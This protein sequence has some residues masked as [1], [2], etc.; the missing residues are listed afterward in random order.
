MT[1]LKLAPDSERLRRIARAYAAGEMDEEEYRRIRAEVIDGFM[2]VDHT[3]DDTEQRWS[4][5]AT[6]PPPAKPASASLWTGQL[7]SRGLRWL[8]GAAVVLVSSIVLL[9]LL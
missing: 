9:L 3:A 1:L 5:P 8:L 7:T 4:P 2:M 6:V